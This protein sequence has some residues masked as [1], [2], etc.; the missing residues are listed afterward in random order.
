MNGVKRRFQLM[1]NDAPKPT[2]VR[3]TSN[4]ID[5]ESGPVI[6]E[7]GEELL[8]EVYEDSENEIQKSKSPIAPLP[9]SSRRTSTRINAAASK[10]IIDENL[11]GFGESGDGED[12]EDYDE[13]GGGGSI[14]EDY[15]EEEDED[16]V[17]QTPMVK[18][19]L[20]DLPKKQKQ[21]LSKNGKSLLKARQQNITTPAPLINEDEQTEEE[22]QEPFII[23]LPAT[24]IKTEKS[25]LYTNQ[26]DFINAEMP[27]ELFDDEDENNEMDPT[28]K[29]PLIGGN[30]LVGKSF[31]TQVESSPKSIDSIINEAVTEK[32]PEEVNLPIPTIE[33]ITNPVNGES[34]SGINKNSWALSKM[35]KNDEVLKLT[36]P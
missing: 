12:D 31:S 35:K 5:S 16:N 26:E 8:D 24:P 17:I 34:S 9:S 3:R 13:G 4:D 33:N 15:D 11:F 14:I 10:A 22:E 27:Q 7:L 2:K 32:R 25:S 23:T 6:R 36:T 29:S 18:R 1:I 20:F 28:K 30:K 19:E 21:K